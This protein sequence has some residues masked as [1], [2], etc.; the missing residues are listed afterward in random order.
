MGTLGGKGLN[1]S[2]NSN[3]SLTWQADINF[4]GDNGK[5]NF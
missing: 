1:E 5:Y 3:S 4:L 2:N